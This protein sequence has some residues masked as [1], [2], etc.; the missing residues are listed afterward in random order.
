MRMNKTGGS[1][2][3]RYRMSYTPG[4]RILLTCTSLLAAT[5]AP[6]ANVF[7]IAALVSYWRTSLINPSTGAHVDIPLD[8]FDIKDPYYIFGTNL[9]SLVCG[10]AGNISLFLNFTNRVPYIFALPVTVVLWFISFAI[11]CFTR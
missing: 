8:G 2:A 3:R 1:Q 9:A 5:I 6:A 4:K 10:Y 7:S 11:V